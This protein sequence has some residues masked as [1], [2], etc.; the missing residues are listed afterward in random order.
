MRP[1]KQF[2]QDLT[3][4]DSPNNICIVDD[5]T[6]FDLWSAIINIMSENRNCVV[7]QTDFSFSFMLLWLKI[8]S[9]KRF[10]QDLLIF[11]IHR[12]LQSRSHQLSVVKISY[13][14]IILWDIAWG[15]FRL[16]RFSF[17]YNL[18]SLCTQYHIID[19]IRTVLTW[20]SQS[21]IRAR[22]HKYT[23]NRTQDKIINLIWTFTFCFKFLDIDCY[24]NKTTIIILEILENYINICYKWLYDEP[25][26]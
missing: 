19:W 15:A 3:P 4:V 6:F 14:E 26:D 25:F 20:K 8:A 24:K 21:R 2:S 10:L 11:L 13:Y 16:A 22:T 1:Q 9:V 17:K 18:G 5:Q 12:C 23:H 7:F